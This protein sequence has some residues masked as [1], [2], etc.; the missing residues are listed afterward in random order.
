MLEKF[1]DILKHEKEEVLKITTPNHIAITLG[2]IA[3]WAE[4]KKVPIEEAYKKSGEIT[5]E[6]IK[7]QIRSNIPILTFYLLPESMDKDSEMFLKLLNSIIE[8]FDNLVNDELITKNRIKISV[9]GKWYD[10]PGR[11]VDSVKKVIDATKD[12][13]SFFVNF[14]INYSG[15][16]EIV[17]ACKLIAMQVK[18]GRLDPDS[19]NK[20]LIKEKIYSS[21]F[22]PPDLLIVNGHKK[23][24]NGLLLWD[25]AYTAVYSS[26]KLWPDFNSTEF[27]KALKWLKR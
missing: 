1:K 3:V 6:I 21:Y 19:I 5:K 24:T 25:L 14:C 12:Y 20:K 11:V 16:E 10:M 17:D 2:G 22:L 13:D 9:L 26:D 15:Q 23:R 18:A 7:E 8:F 27:T 4:N